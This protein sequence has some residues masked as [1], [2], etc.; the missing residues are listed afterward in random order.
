MAGT[1]KTDL[2]S[3][4]IDAIT[5]GLAIRLDATSYPPGSTVRAEIML[6]MSRP[7]EARGLRA[8]IW[9]VET[10]RKTSSRV[11]DTYDYREDASVG[12]PRSTHMRTSTTIVEKTIYS[13]EKEVSGRGEFGSGAHEVEFRI[14]AT[15]SATKHSFGNDGKKAVW[16]IEAKLDIPTALDVRATREIIVE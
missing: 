10:E 15:A 8:R 3:K 9:C 5:S 12:V 13:E 6:R 14:P 16:M 7:M 2:I 11:M 1:K 4:Q